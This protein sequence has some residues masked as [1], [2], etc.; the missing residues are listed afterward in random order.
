MPAY[1][2]R[3]KECTNEFIVFLSIKEYASNPKMKCPHCGSDH[4]KKKLSEFTTKTS[5]KS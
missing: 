3:C 5:K 1:E 4:V 2:Y